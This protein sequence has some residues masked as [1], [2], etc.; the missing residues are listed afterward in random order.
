MWFRRKEKC[1][2]HEWRFSDYRTNVTPYDVE[3]IYEITCTK[4][5]KVRILDEYDFEKMKRLGLIKGE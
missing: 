1:H 4:C 3:R 5:F 2:F